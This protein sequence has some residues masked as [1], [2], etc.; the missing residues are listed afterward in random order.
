MGL[1]NPIAKALTILP[2]GQI[3]QPQG[4]QH[5]IIFYG[6]LFKQALYQG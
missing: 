6:E 1:D 4:I 3:P 2:E 5:A